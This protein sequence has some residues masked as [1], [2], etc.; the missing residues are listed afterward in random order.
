MSSRLHNKFHRH[1]H[2]TTSTN[3]ARYPDASFDPIASYTVPF[4]G[5]FVVQSSAGAALK[6][7]AVQTNVAIDA[8]GDIVTT[9]KFIGDGSG[10]TN[11][12]VTSIV[13]L[14]GSPYQFGGAL[15]GNSI[16]PAFSGIGNAALGKYST[17]AGGS[18]NYIATGNDLSFIA[19]GSSNVINVPNAFVLGSNITANTANTTYVN[20]L[21]TGSGTITTTGTIN[22]G[23]IITTGTVNTGTGNI[24]T[25]GIVNAGSFTGIGTNIN[26]SINPLS[27]TTTTLVNTVSTT[28]NASI[29][30]L[31]ANYVSNTVLRSLSGNWQNVYTLINTTTAT[32]FNVNNIN[33]AGFIN[34]S[35]QTTIGN[36]SNYTS[37]VGSSININNGSG[38][39]T[40]TTNI[41]TNTA[42]GAI[43]IGN[44]SNANVSINGGPL[45]INTTLGTT[46]LGNTSNYTTIAG[47]TITYTGN[48]LFNDSVGIGTTTPNSKLTVI[49]NISAT[50]VIN[51]PLVNLGTTLLTATLNVS[52]L[53]ITGAAS[54]SVFN[55]VQNT[56]AGVSASTDISLYNNDGVN[57][58]D[59]GIA[60]TNYNGNLY[61]PVFNVV[62]A[63]DSYV[64][65]TSGNLVQGA[66]AVTGNLTFFTGGTLSGNER[67]RITNTG[68]V[69]VGTTAPNNKLT[70]VGSISAT[71]VTSVSALQINNSA[72]TNPTAGTAVLVTGTGGSTKTVNNNRVTS[73]SII[74]LT[75]QN[76]AGTVGSLSVSARTP[77]TSF[78]I[79]STSAADTSTV[80]WLIVEPV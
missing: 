18:A 69:G 28:L 31:S 20:N 66:A 30:S 39:N 36:S 59:L 21:N 56:V 64:Y 32:T 23:N 38:G 65:A 57:Y 55:Q 51:T 72:S 35:S 33:V 16:S 2:H 80:G 46:N 40:G 76:N 11:V 45:N 67:M 48:S 19:A 42:S 73:N 41:N 71:G 15:S 75:A 78:T 54:G 3:D 44:S 22:A 53:T 60:S 5:T 47:A 14:S 29:T 37:M 70:V 12:Q 63:G 61:S 49:G 25:T 24:T 26:L 4:N 27:A 9:G 52:P 13:N 10:L 74:F 68:N 58:L 79:K 43:N 17:I 7:S 34:P 6:Y 77:G 8:G 62:N 50:G 1:N